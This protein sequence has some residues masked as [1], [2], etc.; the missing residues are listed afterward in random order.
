MLAFL[1][2][3]NLLFAL[4]AWCCSEKTVSAVRICNV[5]DYGAVVD[6]PFLIRQLPGG[7]AYSISTCA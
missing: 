3:F 7:G 4:W 1:S 5:V 6:I 2:S